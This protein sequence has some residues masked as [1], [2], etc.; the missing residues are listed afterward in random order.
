M[1]RSEIKEYLE[2]DYL[3][4]RV[5]FEIIGNPKEHVETTLNSLLERL[6]KEE[7]I[8]IAEKDIEPAE[9]TENKLFSAYCETELLIKDLYKLTW[10]IFNYTPASVE[11]LEPGQMTLKDNR[12]NAFFGD[13]LAKL[14]ES[15][16]KIVNVSNNNI[17]LQQSMNALLRNAALNVIKEDSL[18]PEQIGKPLGISSEHIKKILEKMIKEGTLIK[19]G[20]KYKR[21]TKKN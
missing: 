4:V 15:N 7:D 1:K 11:L 19:D 10:V 17:G 13:L 20:E 16:Q 5:I 8:K 21:P 2:E 14:H 18:T 6:E 3:L 12:F 9:E